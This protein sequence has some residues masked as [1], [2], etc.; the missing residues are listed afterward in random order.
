MLIVL[1]SL[2]FVFHMNQE[3]LFLLLKLNS[4]ILVNSKC[5]YSMIR[6]FI[7]K[8]WGIG[9]LSIQYRKVKNK[10]SKT[11][12]NITTT[13]KWDFL[14]VPSFVKTIGHFVCTAYIKSCYLL[15]FSEILFV[16][17]ILNYSFFSQSFAANLW[18]GVSYKPRY[19]QTGFINLVP[20]SST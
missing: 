20:Y 4:S 7:L 12:Q 3:A 18:H 8:T 19:R 17:I 15:E 2:F 13:A 1:E 16:W 9:F 5:F 6:Y 10:L 11:K 14:T